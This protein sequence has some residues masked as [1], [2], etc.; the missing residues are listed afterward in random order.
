VSPFGW[1]LYD[2]AKTV[3]VSLARNGPSFNSTT[4]NP[5][6]A[7]SWPLFK[8]IIAHDVARSRD[9]STAVVGGNNPFGQRQLGIVAAHEL[10]LGLFGSQRANALAAIDQKYNQ[11]SLIVADLSNDAT[12]AETL[13]QRFPGRVV[14]LQISRHGDGMGAEPRFTSY[15]PLWV[16][17]IG[18]TL[19]LEQLHREFEADL[20]RLGTSVDIRRGFEQLANLE[21]DYREGGTVYQ[22]PVGQH[23]DLGISFAMLCWAAQHSHLSLWTRDIEARHRPR[24]MRQKFG[25]GAFT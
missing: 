15:G 10:P 25:W 14:G 6:D 21:V 22:C 1:Q 12:Y 24:Q 2:R 11:K 23:D 13:L 7:S 3:H 20:V 16:Y 8:P 5:S 4:Y 17:T 19:L 18:R 9:R